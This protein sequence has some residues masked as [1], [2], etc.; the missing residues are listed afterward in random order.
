MR[1]RE[2]ECALLEGMIAAVRQSESRTLVVRGEA[3]V[4]KTALL[5]YAVESAADAS[6]AVRWIMSRAGVKTGARVLDAPCGFGRHS[7][8]LGR[9]GHRVTGVDFSETRSEERRVGKECGLL[10]RSRWS[11]Y[12]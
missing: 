9:L 12:H 10:C 6:G 4:G 3:G 5:N 1:G 8:E 11:P 2:T 7:I